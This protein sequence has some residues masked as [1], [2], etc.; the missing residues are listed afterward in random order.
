MYNMM[1][2]D[3]ILIGGGADAASSRNRDLRNLVLAAGACRRAI[4]KGFCCFVAAGW[5]LT[6]NDFPFTSV[7]GTFAL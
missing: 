2:I 7:D 3:A 1:A 5:S 4:R 6:S